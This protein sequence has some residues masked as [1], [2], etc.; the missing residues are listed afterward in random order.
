MSEH[1]KHS[2]KAAGERDQPSYS[3]PD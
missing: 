2:L 3:L 1:F